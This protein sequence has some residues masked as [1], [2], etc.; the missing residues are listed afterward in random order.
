MKLAATITSA[1][2]ATVDENTGSNQVI[3]TATADDSA[4]ISDGV[5]FSLAEGSDGALSIDSVTGAVTLADN[6]DYETQS[7][8]SFTLVATDAAGN[9]S[10]Q[11]VT[12]DINN[13]DDTAAVIT[14]VIQ[15]MRL[16]KTPVQGR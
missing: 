5:T 1:D 2:S 16:M 6:P 8:Y 13:L 15:L 4:D 7:N 14:S 3:Y 10:Q 9:E 11:S 12:L